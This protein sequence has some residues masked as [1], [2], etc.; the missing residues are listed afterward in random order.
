MQGGEA[1]S[2][3]HLQKRLVG[4][5]EELR[6]FLYP[7]FSELIPRGWVEEGWR[8]VFGASSLGGFSSLLSVHLEPP[9]HPSGW[10]TLCLTAGQDSSTTFHASSVPVV[11]AWLSRAASMEGNLGWESCFCHIFA[12]LS[13]GSRT[14]AFMGAS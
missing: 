8:K 10:T 13:H 6:P 9:L 7:H 4:D 12:F 5:L 2:S 11:L 1:G 3:L 14:K